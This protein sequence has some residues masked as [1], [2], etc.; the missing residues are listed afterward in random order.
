[1]YSVLLLCTYSGMPNECQMCVAGCKLYVRY[2]ESGW[3]HQCLESK[4]SPT[5]EYSL[6]QSNL[7]ENCFGG[8][9]GPATLIALQPPFFVAGA[10]TSQGLQIHPLSDIV[11]TL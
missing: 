6:C 7:S 11:A 9:N 2:S 8:P 3:Q 5:E 10:L 1:M 4:P